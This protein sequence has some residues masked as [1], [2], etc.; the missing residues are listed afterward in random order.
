MTPRYL[1]PSKTS[2]V[3]ISLASFPIA[4]L[5]TILGGLVLIYTPLG[6]ALGT[7]WVP[8]IDATIRWGGGIFG[9]A[10]VL[11]LVQM[12]RV[13]FDRDSEHRKLS[14]LVCAIMAILCLTVPLAV[15]Y[16]FLANGSQTG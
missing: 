12:S 13:V 11:N 7:G 15:A 2:P 6:R 1:F 14:I 8:A 16:L 10:F 9:L 3:N 5:F 4:A